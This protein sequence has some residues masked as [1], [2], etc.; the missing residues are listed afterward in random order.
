MFSMKSRGI[1]RCVRAFICLSH[2]LHSTFW[3][4]LSIFWSYIE[5]S[6]YYLLP[7]MR[8]LLPVHRHSFPPLR[9]FFLSSPLSSLHACLPTFQDSESPCLTVSYIQI[10]SLS[11]VIPLHHR[12]RCKQCA[13][14]CSIPACYP[15]VEPLSS[16]SHTPLANL[17]TTLKVTKRDPS[18][19]FKYGNDR[20]ILSNQS[21]FC[22]S[23]SHLMV[24]HRHFQVAICSYRQR[25]RSHT[26]HTRAELRS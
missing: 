21:P 5:L 8:L 17:S 23:V 2:L 24:T 15:E 11:L 18:H 16:P 26:T 1:Q 12:M 9:H 14:L 13:M 20:H 7:S 10:S 22:P 25:T 4:S 19:R 6:T 3:M